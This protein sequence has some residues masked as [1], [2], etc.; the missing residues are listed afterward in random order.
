MDEAGAKDLAVRI[1]DTTT[2]VS[3]G[4]DGMLELAALADMEMLVTAVV[5]MIGIRPT[6]EAIRAGKDIALANKE[7]LVTA[8]HLIMPQRDLPVS[9]QRRDPHVHEDPTDCIRRAFP[10]I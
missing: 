10:W 8:G 5:G 6:M 2:R 9:A 1:R 7:T 3:M 4:M